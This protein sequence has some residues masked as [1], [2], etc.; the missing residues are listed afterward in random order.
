MLFTKFM[1]DIVGM[2]VDDQI[3]AVKSKLDEPIPDFR[4]PS[5]LYATHIKNSSI[6]SVFAM[7]YTIQVSKN[8]DKMAILQVCRKYI[9]FLFYLFY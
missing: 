9:Y 6:A 4:L 1:P 3:R 5:E 7:Y 2:M 8:K